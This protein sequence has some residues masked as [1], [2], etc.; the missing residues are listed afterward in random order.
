MCYNIC[1]W[2]LSKEKFSNVF[3]LRQMALDGGGSLES[4]P[5]I[6]TCATTTVCCVVTLQLSTTIF[7]LPQKLPTTTSQK[8]KHGE[9]LGL[10]VTK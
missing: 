10:A 7:V 1:L 6:P 3:N 5:S 2:H 8:H 4:S 9:I